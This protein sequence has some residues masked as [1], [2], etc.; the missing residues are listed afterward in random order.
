MQS[1]GD[2]SNG[3]SEPVYGDNHELVAFTKPAHAF[4]PT[5]SVA[6]C[7]SGRGVAEARSGMMPAAVMASCCWLTDCCPVETR[8]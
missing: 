4:R 7:A 5:G 1:G 8:R 2:L 3:S 6:T